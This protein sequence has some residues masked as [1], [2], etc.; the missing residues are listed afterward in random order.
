MSSGADLLLLVEMIHREKDIEPE[1]LFTGIEQA[2]ESAVRKKFDEDDDI[3]VH[4]DRQ[5]GEIFAVRQGAYVKA[6]DL[7]RIAAQTAK[8]VIIQ[9]IREAEQDVVYGEFETRR[10]ELTTGVIQRFERDDVIVS[11]GRGE[12]VLR[13]SERVRSENH[14][15]GDQIRALVLDVQRQGNRV[16]VL[17]SR[18]HP[19]LI[20][21]LFELEVPE[22]LEGIIEIKQMA[23]EPGYRTKIAVASYDPKVDCVGA[24]VGV[25]GSRIRNII[26]ELNGEKIDIIRWSDSAE[27]LILNALKPAEIESITLNDL[28]QEADVVVAEDQLSLAIG[29]KGQNVRLAHK[30]TGWVINIISASRPQGEPSSQPTEEGTESPE[31]E[32]AS[33]TAVPSELETPAPE[34]ETAPVE[35][36]EPQASPEPVAEPEKQDDSS[37]VEGIV[38]GPGA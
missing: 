20:R 37:S 10:R 25:R 9:K 17:L 5:S 28:T 1:I 14:R 38:D 2:L 29:K 6:A 18:T 15:V 13:R 11:L 8:Q 4:I 36:A 23:R 35:P 31:G 27:V 3:Q 26:D 32:E 12:G 33:A 16:R 24:C 7:G 22:I 34:G 30:L 21:R 19:D